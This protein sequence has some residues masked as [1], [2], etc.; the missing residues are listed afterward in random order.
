VKKTRY[1]GII[2]VKGTWL[3]EWA[4]MVR[5]YIKGDEKKKEEF[6]SY[7]TA[8]DWEII[9]GM[10]I[11]SQVYAYDF[12][13]RLGRAVFH[14]VA[15]ENLE[16]TRAFGKLLMKNLLIVYK[17]LLV[18]NDP[19]AS[20]KKLVEYHSF[21]F[22]NVVSRTSVK[23]EGEKFITILLTLTKED[24]KYVEAAEAFAYQLAGSF[25]ELIAQAGAENVQ[26]IIEKTP[27]GN[28]QYNATWQ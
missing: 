7:L 12:F 13:Q 15:K 20:A 24:K 19:I 2:G 11:P 25:E 4:K 8:N 6:N 3:I 21:C 27:E 26:M 22:I 18:A 9:N 1:N 28:F 16:A 5:K 17:N 14:I 23:E 10:I